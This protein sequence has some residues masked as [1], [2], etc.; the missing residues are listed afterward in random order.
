[1][2]I[3][4]RKRK[5]V[6]MKISGSVIEQQHLNRERYMAKLHKMVSFHLGCLL[7]GSRFMISNSINRRVFSDEENGQHHGDRGVVSNLLKT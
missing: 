1:M 5:K 6:N 3:R 2:A 7:R 4:K